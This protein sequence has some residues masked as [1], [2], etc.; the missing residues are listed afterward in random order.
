[1]RGLRN[2]GAALLFLVGVWSAPPWGGGSAAVAAPISQ[3]VAESEAAARAASVGGPAG[4]EAALVDCWSSTAGYGVEALSACVLRER[5]A[6]ALILRVSAL[7]GSV[8]RPGLSA[9]ASARRIVEAYAARGAGARAAADLDNAEPEFIDYAIAR[10]V[11]D[12]FETALALDDVAALTRSAAR[13]AAQTGAE[14]AIVEEAAACWMRLALGRPRGA[15]AIATANADARLGGEAAAEAWRCR[16]LEA[17]AR[18]DAG[19]DARRGAFFR[20]L[21]AA[22]AEAEAAAIAVAARLFK[23]QGG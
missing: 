20:S 8:E 5:A 21:T 6:R 7:I 18:G 23:A 10:R 16:V 15:G 22:S 13:L 9:E 1:M 12:G 14:S 17:L 19:V 11:A 4:L 3:I 2:R